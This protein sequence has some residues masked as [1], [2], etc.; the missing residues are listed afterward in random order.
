MNASLAKEE[1]SSKHWEQEAK[2]G[3]KRIMRAEKEKDKAKQEGRVAELFVTVVGDDK[4]G[5][6]NHLTKALNALAAAEEGE[7]KLEAEIARL[8]AE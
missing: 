8:A 3:M 4:A 7:H 1:S 6:E 2:Y 5:V